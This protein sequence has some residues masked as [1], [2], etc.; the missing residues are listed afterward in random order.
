LPASRAIEH[1]QSQNKWLTLF[2]LLLLIGMVVV[3]SLPTIN[4]PGTS[5]IQDQASITTS[6]EGLQRGSNRFTLWLT[7]TS[8]EQTIELFPTS[9]ALSDNQGNT[10]QLRSVLDMSTTETI[11]P[12]GRIKLDY[13]LNRAISESATSITF[14]LDGIYGRSANSSH[15]KPLPAVQWTSNL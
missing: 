11:P 3:V 8:S 14:T 1:P 4:S 5:I 13:I 6:V 7:N 9:I 15:E 10:Y 2:G 12:N